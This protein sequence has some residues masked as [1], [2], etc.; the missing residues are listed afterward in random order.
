[1]TEQELMWILQYRDLGLIK[2]FKTY[3]NPKFFHSSY[4][5]YLNITPIAI[6]KIKIKNAIHTTPKI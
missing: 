6:F 4:Y 5:E 3:T 2:Y 1:M